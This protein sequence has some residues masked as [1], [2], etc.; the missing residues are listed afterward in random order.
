MDQKV[1]EY[2]QYGTND[3]AQIAIQNKLSADLRKIREEQLDRE[4]EEYQNMTLW[5]QIKH[6][7]DLSPKDIFMLAF[8]FISVVLIFCWAIPAQKRANLSR[9]LMDE[10][11]WRNNLDF[12]S[13]DHLVKMGNKRMEIIK[14]LKQVKNLKT[15]SN[16]QDYEKTMKRIKNMKAL[17]RM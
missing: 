6:D 2:E 10:W 9:K 15:I 1:K 3:P 17:G 11:A 14:Q 7:Y 12:K 4:W 13:H 8:I 5:Q 16:Y